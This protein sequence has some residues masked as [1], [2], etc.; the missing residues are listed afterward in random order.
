LIGEKIVISPSLLALSAAVIPGEQE[1]ISR[2]LKVPVN[3]EGF[4]QEAHAK[5]RPVDFATDGIFVCGLAHSPKPIDES[6]SQAQAAAARAA[7]PLSRGYVL[8][9][10]VVSSVDPDKCFGCGIC[11][12]LCPYG[13]IEVVETDRGNKAQTITASCKGCGICA[14]KCPRMAITMGGFTGEQ[15]LSQIEALAVNF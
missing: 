9:E 13:S 4:F 2:L 1:E 10:P 5:L 12:Y 6:I 3:S 14:S 11:E 7:I 15:I 8:V